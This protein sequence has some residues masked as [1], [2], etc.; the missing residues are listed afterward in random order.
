M[1]L[2]FIGEG[3]DDSSNPLQLYRT[4]YEESLYLSFSLSLSLSLPLSLSRTHC[5]T[6]RSIAAI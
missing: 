3:K 4:P 1:S 5:I 6:L 2:K